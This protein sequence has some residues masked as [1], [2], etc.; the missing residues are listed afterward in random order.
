MRGSCAIHA[1]GSPDELGKKGAWVAGWGGALQT[2]QAV[3]CLEGCHRAQGTSPILLAKHPGLRQ[4]TCQAATCYF[5]LR[6]PRHVIVH[7]PPN[8]NATFDLKL[9]ASA[10][11]FLN[12]NGTVHFKN[13]ELFRTALNQNTTV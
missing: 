5:P 6:A 13:Q 12:H 1:R 4:A 2:M 3:L 10:N 8:Q 7:T 11:D 9:R